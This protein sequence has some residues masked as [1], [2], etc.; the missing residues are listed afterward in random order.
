MGLRERM[1]K[2]WVSLR[3]WDMKLHSG[4]EAFIKHC[5]SMK[6]FAGNTS[7]APPCTVKWHWRK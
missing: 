4:T 2:L 3:L 7:V 1:G 5:Q 6:I